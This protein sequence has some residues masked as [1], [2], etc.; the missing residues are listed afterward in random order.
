MFNSY[1]QTPL[2]HL[3]RSADLTSIA[4]KVETRLL[5][6]ARF[7]PDFLTTNQL[8]K[9]LKYSQLDLTFL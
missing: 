3:T 8:N 2:R 4:T 7:Q 1:T 6:S 5:S 9:S